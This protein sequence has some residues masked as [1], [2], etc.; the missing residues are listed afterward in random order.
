MAP[1]NGLVARLV[2]GP[3]NESNVASVR[4]DN[5]LPLSEL[6]AQSQSERAENFAFTS[7][8]EVLLKDVLAGDDEANC[9]GQH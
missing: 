2:G 6:A 9:N 1:Q 8:D 5:V 7:D 3:P 4:G